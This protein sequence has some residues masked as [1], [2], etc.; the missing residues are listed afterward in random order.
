[1]ALLAL[2]IS[3]LKAN[4][5]ML[6]AILAALPVVCTFMVCVWNHLNPKAAG[7]AP[8]S[9][10]GD[11]WKLRGGEPPE[12]FLDAHSRRISQVAARG[13]QVIPVRGG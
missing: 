5:G 12:T 9:D 8:R 11:S 1:M 3:G 7:V 10:S 2:A 13:V 6:V 4:D